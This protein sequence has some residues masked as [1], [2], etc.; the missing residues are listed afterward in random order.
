[1]TMNVDK[2]ENVRKQKRKLPANRVILRMTTRQHR[3]R[4]ERFV[5]MH[6]IL[7]AIRMYARTYTCMLA[8]ILGQH[9]TFTVTR[10]MFNFNAY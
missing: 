5:Q 9:F 4:L 7:Y 1:M 3:H 2:N 6:H 8:L 10:N